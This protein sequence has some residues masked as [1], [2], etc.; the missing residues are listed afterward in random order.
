M[1]L[2]TLVGGVA[3]PGGETAEAAL[4]ASLAFTATISVGTSYPFISP[5]VSVLVTLAIV[6]QRRSGGLA[7]LQAQGLRRWEILT[8]YSLGVFLLALIPAFFALLVLPP[9]VE[10]ALAS[11][12]QLGVLYPLEYW[13]A[14]PRLF[15]ATLFTVLFAATFAI[16][17]RNPAVAFGAMVTFF[18]VGWF[19]REPLRP[20]GSLTP[21]GAFQ[22]AYFYEFSNP[23][24]LPFLA[25]DFYLVYIVLAIVA[26]L[27]AVLY[28]SR[29]G[30]ML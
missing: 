14:M 17:I 22:R 6:T 16:L 21:P 10:P 8:A 5:L 25:A 26:F 1:L 13:I 24:G 2:F 4:A 12:G 27:L 23:A 18:F 11:Q 9:I 30:E 7:A 3:R 29:R 20:Y 15:L 28:A 19:L